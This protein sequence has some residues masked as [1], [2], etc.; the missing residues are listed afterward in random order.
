MPT[1]LF[2]VIVPL[3]ALSGCTHSLSKFYPEIIPKN[4]ETILSVSGQSNHQVNLVYLGAGN[5]VLEQ[6][7]EAIITDPFFSNQKLLKL[8]GKVKSNTQ[9]FSTWKTNYQYFLSPSVVRAALVSHTHYDHTMDLP[10]LLED[11]YF[12]N[13]KVVYG[14]SYLPQI[15]QNFNKQGVNLSELSKNQVY[16]P[17]G[18]SGKDYQWISVTPRIRFLPILSN[19]AP[20]TKKKLYMDKSLDAEY[21]D[22]HL[23][24]S[25]SKTKAFKWSTGDTYSF[26]VDF[27]DTDTLRVFIQTSASQHPFGFPPSYEIK[28]KKVD[29]AILCYASALNVDNYPNA[30]INFVKPKK[31]V[32]VHWEDFF[33][34]P[35]SFHDQR[36]VRRT[37]PKKVREQID[38][39]GKTNDYFMMPKP[40]T[41]IKIKY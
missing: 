37:N 9:L 12:T 6:N 26:L 25:N 31:L 30:L 20:H 1:R 15:L 11:R 3:I 29:V 4:S 13:L 41:R 14:N 7:G 21:F 32:F 36:L 18:G 28:K 33:R 10:L 24:Y 17:T 8:L 27:I 16:D 5:M 23:I 38:K 34:A 22:E 40:G 35:E 39:L 2:I 19:H